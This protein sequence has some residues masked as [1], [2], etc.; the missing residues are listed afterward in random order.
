MEPIAQLYQ[1]ILEVAL[2]HQAPAGTS[3][4][5][6]AGAQAGFTETDGSHKILALSSEFL[7]R[8]FD[9]HE[10]PNG[11]DYVMRMREVLTE[12][13]P[14]S[15]FLIAPYVS[16]RHLSHAVRSTYPGAELQ[17]IAL[18]VAAENLAPGSMLGALLP[19]YSTSSD[20]ALSVRR[21]LYRNAKPRYVIDLG[22][23]H[24][25]V[26]QNVHPDFEFQV[27]ILETGS[28]N[29]PGVRFFRI[30]EVETQIQINRIL[31]DFR[32]LAHQGGGETEYGY[33]LRHELAP[34]DKL[35]FSLHDP[36][37][38]RRVEDMRHLGQLVELGDIAELLLSPQ[39]ARTNGERAIGNGPQGIVPVLQARDIRRDGRIEAEERKD[40]AA[41]SRSDLMLQ[42]GDICVRQLYGAF[43]GLVAA[44]VTP[45]MLPCAAGKSILVVRPLASTWINQDYLIGYLRSK[46]AAE[47]LPAQGVGLRLTPA[48]LAK[49][50]VPVPDDE[51]TTALASL[52]ICP[53]TTSGF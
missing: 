36:R 22:I 25:A 14:R 15:A 32:R 7:P 39:Y 53:R 31:S 8:D 50:P 29:Q 42:P 20:R 2:S 46:R 19:R 5:F 47:W 6:V 10:F 45:D 3:M 23:S 17:E 37:L 34:E 26:F 1:Q 11:E 4:A 24:R 43:D 33:V 28:G 41:T 9:I 30:P 40:T 48:T 13:H 52:S 51:L 44:L 12:K 35:L 21:Q 16:A 27:L 49:L 18:L 38:K